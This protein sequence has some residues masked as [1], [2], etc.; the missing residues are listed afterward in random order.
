MTW[1][2][3]QNK[4]NVDPWS[5]SVKDDPACECFKGNEYATALDAMASI[6]DLMIDVENDE[7]YIIVVKN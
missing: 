2:I 5:I 4:D 6:H 7:G 3:T 1:I